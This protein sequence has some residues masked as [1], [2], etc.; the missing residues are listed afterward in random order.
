MVDT[1][2]QEQVQACLRYLATHGTGLAQAEASQIK[3]MSGHRSL[4]DGQV[5]FSGSLDWR[6]VG[7]V[8][9]PV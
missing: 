5:L 4:S 9:D 8:V 6:E 3:Y 1:S 7:G 2:L